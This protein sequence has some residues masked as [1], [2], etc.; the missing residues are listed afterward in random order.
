MYFNWNI[1][2]FVLLGNTFSLDFQNM[3]L[4]NSSVRDKSFSCLRLCLGFLALAFG[5]IYLLFSIH[6]LD[7]ISDIGFKL[8]IQLDF[9]IVTQKNAKTQQ[10]ERF[11]ICK[12]ISGSHPCAVILTMEG[13][14]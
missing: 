1:L 8:L 9:I 7:Q 14:E 5:M 10:Q 4:I 6:D 3:E 13:P 2:W 12:K 11:E